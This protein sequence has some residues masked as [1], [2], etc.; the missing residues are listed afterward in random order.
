MWEAAKAL[1][2]AENHQVVPKL[3]DLM[4]TSCDAERRVAAAWTLGF[5]RSSAALEP[6]IKILDNRSEPSTLRDQAAESLG[7]VSDPKAR[8]VLARN[9]FDENADVAFSCA[10]AFRTV[11]ISDDIP[12]LEKLATKSS[13]TN[14]YG[15]YVAQEAREAI[16]QIR[17]R[18]K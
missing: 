14:S 12:L 4:A 1:V 9:L 7:Y 16:E 11:G 18:D 13:L 2:A 15:A 6:L 8:E 5:L 3:L 10:F 17:S